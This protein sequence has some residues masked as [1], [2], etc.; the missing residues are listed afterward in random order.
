ME[1][2]NRYWLKLWRKIDESEIFN[3]GSAL[4]VFI[5]ILT[6]VDKEGKMKCGRFWASERLGLNP[7][8]FYKILKRIEK[9][10]KSVTLI[11]NNKNTIISLSNW[12][13]YQS[14]DK[15]ITCI[16]N[17]KVTTKEQQSNT[18]QEYKNKEVKNTNTNVLVVKD[19]NYF[20]TLFRGVNPTYERLY[21]NK[22]QRASIDRLRKKLTDE[23]LENAITNLTKIISIPYAPRITTPYELEM[24]LGSYIAF[25]NQEKNKTSKF[26]IGVI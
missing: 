15:K 26:N 10:Y 25:M 1:Q 8:T 6:N 13:K 17:N 18:I 19:T 3:D 23:Q 16:S 4:R 20:I 2:T 22:T 11:S 9:K 12:S 14:S 7:S 24:K 5:W 21:A